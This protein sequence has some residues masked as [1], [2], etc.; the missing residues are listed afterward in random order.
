MLEVSLTLQV[1]SYWPFYPFQVANQISSV[2]CSDSTIAK[3]VSDPKETPEAIRAA[4]KLIVAVDIGTT[5]TKVAWSWT[6]LAELEACLFMDGQW[7]DQRQVPT[8]VLYRPSQHRRPP[9]EFDSFGCEAIQKHK[10]GNQGC[11]LFQPFKMQLH[12]IEVST[13]SS[14]AC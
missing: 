1:Y 13:L 5:Y 11:A 10:V 9:W 14:C 2:Q 6:K 8:A 3:N 4:Y 7:G 12:M